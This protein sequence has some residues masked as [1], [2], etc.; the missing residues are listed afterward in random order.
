MAC[1][2]RVPAVLATVLFVVALV[3]AVLVPSVGMFWL[4]L[5]LLGGPIHAIL[6][7]IGARR[8]Q[9]KSS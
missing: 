4:L 1:E 2:H 7:R 3:L 5:L 9:E 6:D 8:V